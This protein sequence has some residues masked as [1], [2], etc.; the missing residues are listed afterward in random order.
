MILINMSLITLITLTLLYQYCDS[1]KKALEKLSQCQKGGMFCGDPLWQQYKDNGEDMFNYNEKI[2]NIVNFMQIIYT[3]LA[4]KAKPIASRV[5]FNFSVKMHVNLKTCT[6]YK[7]G[8]FKKH[9]F[10]KLR[11]FCIEVILSIFF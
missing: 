1:S 2:L 3:I 9:S 6:N 11:L 10:E 7:V 8:L 4:P 5:K